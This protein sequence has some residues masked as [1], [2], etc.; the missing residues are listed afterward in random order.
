MSAEGDAALIVSLFAIDPAGLG[1]VCVRSPV[2]PARD[3][4]LQALRASLPEGTPL[5]KVPASIPDGRLLGGLDL[6]A[7]LKANRPIAERGVLA[8]AHD[9]R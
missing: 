5:R 9:S 6:V 2:H 8:E 1:G 7:T 3:Q 4:W